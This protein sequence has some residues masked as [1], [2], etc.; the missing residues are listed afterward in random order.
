MQA[1]SAG[2]LAEDYVLDKYYVDNCVSVIIP[3]FN[4]E[5]IIART[6]DEV[7]KVLEKLG[8]CY[9]II[10]VDD[11]SIDST[12][13]NARKLVNGDACRIVRAYRLSRNKGKGFA[14]LYGFMKSSCNKI[15]FFDGDLDI[16]VKQ[17]PILLKALEHPSVDIV[18][19][20]KW[21]RLSRTIASPTRMILSKAF[22]LLTKALLGLRIRD[23][24]T[25]AKALK[26]RV[27]EA[28]TPRLLVKR[29]AFDAELLAAAQA[30]KFNIV[31]V[32]S[33]Y[34]IKLTSRFKLKEIFHM[35]LDLIAT[36]YRLR[37]K[38]WYNTPTRYPQMLQ[39][40]LGNVGRQHLADNSIVA[41]TPHNPSQEGTRLHS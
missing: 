3:A 23:T 7:K 1:N 5:K 18:V 8:Y 27:L 6:I 16:P 11:G 26:R 4:L 22:S 19:T 39:E 21:H 32:P 20:S 34:P 28:I 13:E 36:T 14:L 33:V 38:K 31:E 30:N 29:Y 12:Y 2:S 41:R 35:L 15:L 17:I 10:V 25:G 24:Q 9:E 40:Y 37:V